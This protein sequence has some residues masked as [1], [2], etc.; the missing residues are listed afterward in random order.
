MDSYILDDFGDNHDDSNNEFIDLNDEYVNHYEIAES[1]DIYVDQ[2]YDRM[3]LEEFNQI[4]FLFPNPYRVILFQK[5]RNMGYT[6]DVESA[7]NLVQFV[8]KN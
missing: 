2:M 1:I 3:T 7:G 6:F 5:F 8:Y 4:L